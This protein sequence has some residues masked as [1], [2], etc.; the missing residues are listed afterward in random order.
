MNA[1]RI[2]LSI[3]MLSLS[4]AAC[5][6]PTPAPQ[7]L[8][9]QA[10]PTAAPAQPTQV[11]AQPAPT[12]APWPTSA[13]AAPAQIGAEATAAPIGAAPA[14]TAS[15]MPYATPPADN[16]FRDY[17]VNPYVEAAQDHL[18]TFALDVD[19]ASYTV[20]RRYVQEGNLPPADAVRVEEFV[21][22]FKQDYALPSNV[23]FGLYADGAP[24]PFHRDG[25]YLVRF[26][27]QGYAVPE[28]QR[29]ALNLTF[30]IDV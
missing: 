5:A 27:V 26:G 23:A 21:N 18:S 15:P 14:A 19:T 2:T 13:P 22:F 20:A 9:S 25:S 12:R 7:I 10:R 1:Q 29:K 11:W 3:V 30:V 28:S 4:L 16:T 17:G 24:S 8:S 6:A